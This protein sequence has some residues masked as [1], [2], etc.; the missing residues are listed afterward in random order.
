MK[1]ATP[2]GDT[3]ALRGI[4]MADAPLLYRWRVD[5]RSRDYFHT[6]LGDYGNHAAYV[7][8]FLSKP[9]AD[10]WFMIEAAGIPVGTIALYEVSPERR[11]AEWGRFLIA[12]EARSR[13]YG[14]RALALLVEHARLRGLLELR[15]EV[16]AS[17]A[18]ALALYRRLGFVEAGRERSGGQSLIHLHLPLERP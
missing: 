3:V 18:V 4:T 14:R 15:C 2:A 10:E 16:L 13:G 8:R 11:T 9:G 12:P 5:P 17:N 6:A 1:A 7:E